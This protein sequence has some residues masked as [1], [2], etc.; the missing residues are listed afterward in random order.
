MK[1]LRW[2]PERPLPRRPYRDSALFYAVLACIVVLVGLLTGAS[3]VR[4]VAIAVGA[5]VLA[6]GWSWWR[7]R[8]RLRSQAGKR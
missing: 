7:W 4:T 1:W 5:F 6:T 8:E 3:V 2:E